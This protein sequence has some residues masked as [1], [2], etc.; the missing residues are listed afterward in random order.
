MYFVTLF[1]AMLMANIVKSSAVYARQ[2][3]T[4][5]ACAE[6][7]P[8]P[9][10]LE[11]SKLL[12]AS[13]S[14]SLTRR[15]SQQDFNFNV[16]A[17]VVY[18]DKTAQ[19]GYVEEADI[20]K[21]IEAMNR[22]FDGSGISFTLVSVSYTENQD[23]ATYRDVDAMKDDLREGTYADL[24][25]YYISSIAEDRGQITTSGRCSMPVTFTSNGK[26][27]D[28][29]T[30][31]DIAVSEEY[32]VGDG[33]VIVARAVDGNTVTHEVGHWLGLLHTWKSD[34]SD[35][36]DMIDDTAPQESPTWRCSSVTDQFSDGTPANYACDGWRESN[37]YNFMDYSDCT[38]TFS[39]GQ[40]KRMAYF[41]EYREI[42]GSRGP[43]HHSSRPA[44]AASAPAPAPAP[45]APPEP[46]SDANEGNTQRLRWFKR[47]IFEQEGG[48]DLCMGLAYFKMSGASSLSADHV[49]RACGTEIFCKIIEWDWQ[50]IGPQTMRER[51]G[52]ASHHECIAGHEA[53]P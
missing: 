26:P 42:L 31:K 33:C 12:Q 21:A 34:C 8:S 45:E 9:D 47:S 30:R 10:F 40:K 49:D 11:L 36:G 19:G 16:F 41:A 50:G 20:K 4:I 51:L 44:A 15:Q 32:L 3:E 39:A 46:P 35:E 23:W 6:E 7:A 28:I 38:S 1:M 29:T 24:N 27:V 53:E 13:N 5:L 37:M 2:N 48:Y 14:T 43:T 22:N 25:L 17:H 52:F 18:Y